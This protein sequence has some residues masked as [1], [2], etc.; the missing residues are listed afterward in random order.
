MKYFSKAMIGLDLTEMDDILI[1]KTIVFLKFLG[2]E[3]CY[4]VHVA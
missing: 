2:I 1:E 4:F 3:K